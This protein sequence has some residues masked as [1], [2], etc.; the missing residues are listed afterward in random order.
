MNPIE[1]T[2]KI[3]HTA[4]EFPSAVLNRTPIVGAHSYYR[5]QI[6]IT[7]TDINPLIAAAEPLL[8]V[9]NKLKLL[10]HDAESNRLQLSI[11][12][13]INA[14]ETNAQNRG[15]RAETILIA[16]Y[17]LCAALDETLECT[18]W[19]QTGKWSK[20]QLINSYQR[21]ESTAERFFLILERLCEEPAQHIDLLELIYLCLSLG[22]E[23]KFRQQAKGKIELDKIIDNL[24]QLICQYRQEPQSFIQTEL[25][26]KTVAA[27][28]QIYLKP[29]ILKT[30]SITFTL[31]LLIYLGFAYLFDLVSE[32]VQQQVQKLT[33]V[34]KPFPKD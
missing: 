3:I 18:P 22:F 23:G 29:L 25:N 26:S 4:P 15:Y 16:R 5:S 17:V 32:P 20:Q 13:E 9:S 14:F 24:Y 11:I 19:G 21:E 8:A 27:Q 10:E 34:G 12:H 28:S 31:M 33:L 1:I 6:F 7:Q 2:E 30:T